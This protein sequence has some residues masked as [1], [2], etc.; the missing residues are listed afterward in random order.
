VATCEVRSEVAGTV[1][2][3]EKLVGD[4]VQR[5]DILIIVESMKMEI[6]ITSPANGR[7]SMMAIN[8]GDQI[9]EGTIIST[10]LTSD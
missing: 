2:K 9:S 7:I 10:I 3:V 4:T 8:E 1:W 6:P 5:E